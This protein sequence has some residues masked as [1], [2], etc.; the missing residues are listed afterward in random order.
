ML[1]EESYHSASPFDSPKMKQNKGN[2]RG[3]LKRQQNVSQDSTEDQMQYQMLK[4][5]SKDSGIVTEMITRPKESSK[6]INWS[7]SMHSEKFPR[8]T[9][10]SRD[11]IEYSR[12]SSRSNRSGSST[13]SVKSSGGNVKLKRGKSVKENGQ[14]DYESDEDQSKIE[15]LMPKQNGSLD[16]DQENKKNPSIIRGMWKK[17]FKSL[18]SSGGE[19]LSKKGSVHKKKPDSTEQDEPQCQ[20]S[21]PVDPVYSLLKCAADLPKVGKPPC[22]LH[23]SCTLHSG[24]GS[25]AVSSADSS[26]NT[27]KTSS[28]SSSEMHEIV[29]SSLGSDFKTFYKL[30][31]PTKKIPTPFDHV[32]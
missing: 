1:D 7:E 28:H 25:I 23:A 29:G 11:L 18:K 31:S 17:A 32:L 12:Q 13:K 22:S 26:D 30:T 24:P 27:S 15:L 16:E 14:K 2:S 21:G 3:K 6:D 5:E 19:K 10:S 4:Q 20:S 9:Q 8:D